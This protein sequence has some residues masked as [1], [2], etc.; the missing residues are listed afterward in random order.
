M[1]APLCLLALLV[2][3]AAAAAAAADTPRAPAWSTLAI[4]Q[5]STAFDNF[6]AADFTF[7]TDVLL[8]ATIAKA[9]GKYLGAHWVPPSKVP[10]KSPNAMQGL[11]EILTR[12]Q[13][14]D[15][16]RASPTGPTTSDATTSALLELINI[17]HAMETRPQCTTVGPLHYHPRG[18]ESVYNTG[19]TLP[20][21]VP[22]SNGMYMLLIRE[23]MGRVYF[24][25]LPPG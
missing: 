4:L 5:P 3:C 23:D 6:V 20:G 10:P 18:T 11:Q 22:A 12:I 15:I 25:H 9:G 21:V 2:A 1:R 14:G 16:S 17:N 19:V 13:R 7:A 24:I 8:P